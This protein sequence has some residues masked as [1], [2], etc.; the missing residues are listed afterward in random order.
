MRQRSLTRQRGLS[1][2]GLL[3]IAG[4]VAV[5]GMVGVQVLPTFIEYQAILKATKKAAA[6]G[7]SV[8]EVRTVFDRAASI[9]NIASVQ[10]KDLDVTKEGERIVASFAY[11][12]EIHLA[13]PAYLTLKYT[14]RSR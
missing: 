13:G 3:F 14:G 9:D 6:E 4:L 1:F 5:T 10:G 11:S 7:N 8:L 12:R 2:L